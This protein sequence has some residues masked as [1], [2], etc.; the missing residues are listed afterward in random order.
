MDFERMRNNFSQKY[1]GDRMHEFIG[2]FL[3]E[4][5]PL[6]IEDRR[7]V[8]RMYQDK[9]SYLWGKWSKKLRN[10]VNPPIPADEGLAFHRTLRQDGHIYFQVF[11]GPELLAF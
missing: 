4:F 8:Y 9:E 11:S 5:E 10:S 2:D 3:D 1:N 6:S 7:K